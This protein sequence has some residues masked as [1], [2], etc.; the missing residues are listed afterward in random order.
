MNGHTVGK[1]QE[2]A[3]SKQFPTCA[4][5]KNSAQFHSCNAQCTGIK[6]KGNNVVSHQGTELLEFKTVSAIKIL[7]AKSH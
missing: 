1:M 6:C 5:A 4:F 7:P 2:V 3:I